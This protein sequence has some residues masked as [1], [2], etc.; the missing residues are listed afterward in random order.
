MEADMGAANLPDLRMKSTPENTRANKIRKLLEKGYTPPQIAKAM[1][2]RG[3]GTEKTIRRQAQKLAGQEK[4]FLFGQLSEVRGMGLTAAP[5]AMNGLI[6]RARAG[7]PD[8]VKLLFEVTGIHNPK[9]QHEH[10]GD[11]SIRLE[12]PRPTPPKAI[13][14]EATE[15]S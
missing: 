13:D 7:R 6:R 14:S 4:G 5:D 9:M 11:I 8:A 3:M 10:S 1:A 12:L 2:K 15:V